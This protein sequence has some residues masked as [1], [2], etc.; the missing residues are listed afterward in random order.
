MQRRGTDLP[1]TG[2]DKDTLFGYFGGEIT[3]KPGTCSLAPSSP[4]LAPR[5]SRR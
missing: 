4:T 1:V 2:A 3:L 5:A